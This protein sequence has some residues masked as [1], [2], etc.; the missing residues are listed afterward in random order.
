MLFQLKLFG[1]FYQPSCSPDGSKIAF[2]NDSPFTAA[3]ARIFIYHTVD[4]SITP[5]VSSTGEEPDQGDSDPTWWDD[6][7][8]VFSRL[9]GAA[10]GPSQGLL[11]RVDATG[12]NQSELKDERGNRLDARDNATQPAAVP[13]ALR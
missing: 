10:G 2:R 11:F 12:A 6:G 5:N 1:G 3:A 13:E 9:V 8:I 7:T 4:G